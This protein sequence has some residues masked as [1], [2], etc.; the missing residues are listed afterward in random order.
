[1]GA[2]ACRPPRFDARPATS[3]RAPAGAGERRPGRQSGRRSLDMP[4]LGAYIPDG[5][6]S[7]SAERELLAKLTDLLLKYEGVDPTNE[8]ARKLAWVFVHR[9]QVYVAGTPPRAPRYRFI[10]QVPEGEYND[11]RRAAVTAAMTQA[12][13]RGGGRRLAPSR[14]S[15]VH[16]HLRGPRRWVGRG[17][18]DPQA[19]GNL[20]ARR[21]GQA[22]H[23]RPA[24]RSGQAGA[25]CAQATGGRK[26]SRR[27]WPPTLG[28][29]NRG[30]YYRSA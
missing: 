4:M 8:M 16:L 26:T 28:V 23:G 12:R 1:L 7:P 9:P 29:Q 25:R 22:G 5:A 14:A 19:A 13:G 30:A 3:D 17:G 2:R 10:C 11:E 27:H 21:A 6:L 20:R 18:K 24:S 15:R